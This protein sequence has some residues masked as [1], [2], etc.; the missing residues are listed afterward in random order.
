MRSRRPARALGPSERGDRPQPHGNSLMP[1]G[2][3]LGKTRKALRPP[4]PGNLDRICTAPRSRQD[5]IRRA[6]GAEPLWKG[7]LLSNA[8]RRGIR[9]NSWLHWSLPRPQTLEPFSFTNRGGASEPRIG[10]WPA[11]S[12]PSLA[13]CPGPRS[14]RDEIPDAH[15]AE[16]PTGRDLPCSY[17]TGSYLQEIRRARGP[18]SAREASSN[19]RP[20]QPGSVVGGVRPKSRR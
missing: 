12:L 17:H 16:A 18:S 9:E 20:A 4:P 11:E 14:R 2:V 19:A 8:T 1:L 13:I 6:I 5:E 3:A 15:G 7:V 10:P